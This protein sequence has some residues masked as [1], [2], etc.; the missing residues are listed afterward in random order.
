MFFPTRIQDDPF[1][2][3]PERQKQACALWFIGD[4]HGPMSELLIADRLGI[5]QP[6]VHKLISKGTAYLRATLGEPTRATVRAF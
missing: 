4:D 3:M 5:S 6:A 2:G 1:A